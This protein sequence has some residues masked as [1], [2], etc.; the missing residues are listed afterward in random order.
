MEFVNTCIGLIA[1]MLDLFMGDKYCL[2]LDKYSEIL[3]LL[4]YLS[5]F[6]AYDG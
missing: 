3:Y 2:Y 1:D 4:Y 5:L 6:V